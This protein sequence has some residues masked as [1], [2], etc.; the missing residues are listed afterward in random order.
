MIEAKEART[1]IHR[2][3]RE[4]FRG[5][6]ISET[7]ENK[8]TGEQRIEVFWK[9]PGGKNVE[10]KSK[11][12]CQSSLLP[13]VKITDEGVARAKRSQG[14]ATDHPPYIHFTLQKTNREAHDALSSLCRALH[15]Q[16]RDIGTAG[17]KDKRAVTVQRVSI[18]RGT[19]TIEEVYRASRGGGGGRGG[20]GGRGRGGYGGAQGERGV[21]LGDF[22]Y[23]DHGFE[24][25]MLKGN[26]FVIT[27]RYAF[28]LSCTTDGAKGT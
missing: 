8:E 25:G 20:R 4:N 24:L 28:P 13:A 10:R 6:L 23:A 7:R 15:L 1:A 26:K 3:L 5:R 22:C 9:G 16:P 11:N 12:D 14:L 18:K 2:A 27:L 17:T 19:K 21:V